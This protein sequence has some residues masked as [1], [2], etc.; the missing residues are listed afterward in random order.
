LPAYYSS[1]SNVLPVSFEL[2]ARKRNGV[3]AAHGYQWEYLLE[4]F[5]EGLMTKYYSQHNP[6]SP[7]YPDHP[8]KHDEPHKPVDPRPVDP[9]PSPGDPIT[10]PAD[11]PLL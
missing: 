11:E 5:L 2:A 1:L 4:Y 8:H 3:T 9:D 6:D 10:D 7:D